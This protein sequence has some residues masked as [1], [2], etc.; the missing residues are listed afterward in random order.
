MNDCDLLFLGPDKS[1]QIH[2]QGINCDIEIVKVSKRDD[3]VYL[4]LIKSHEKNS[5]DGKDGECS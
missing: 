3:G 4:V 1:N 2:I 5:L